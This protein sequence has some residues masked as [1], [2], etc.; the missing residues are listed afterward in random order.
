MLI[1]ASQTARAKNQTGTES[2]IRWTLRG[3]NEAIQH[4]AGRES[5]LSGPSETGKTIACLQKLNDLLWHNRGAQAVLVRKVAAT[6]TPTVI[7]TWEKK[8]LGVNSA[9]TP[10]GGEK[11]EWYD[12]PNGSRL[13]IAGMDK[14]G[15]TLSAERDFVYV[16]QAEELALADWEHLIR[17][18]TGRAGNAPHPQIFADCNPGG[19]SHWILQRPS[20]KLF[21]SRHEDNPSL[22]DDAGN[23]TGRGRETLTTLDTLSGARHKRLRL[24]LW[25]QEEGLV[26]DEFDAPNLTDE[27]PDLSLPFELAADDGYAPDPRVI[28]FIQRTPGRVLV[29]DELCHLRHLAETCIKETIERSGNIFGWMDMEGRSLA[30]EPARDRKADDRRPARLPSICVGSPEAKELQMRFRQA[31]IPYRAPGIKRIV[32]G[33]A[34]VRRLIKDSNEQRVLQINRRCKNFIWELTEGY[35]NP[36]AGSRRDDENPIDANNHGCDAFR[37]WATLR[38]AR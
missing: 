7:Q 17:I 34:V 22:F 31:N 4:Y 9:V 12:Y 10:F 37:Y 1:A 13:W 5:V 6:I 21:I 29:F 36:V 24:G 35:K 2:N 20:L 8:I 3:D 11:P 19:S 18:V 15:R 14:P 25:S 28:L 38:A 16:N 27:E 26:Y 23:L 32:D 33:I 30:S